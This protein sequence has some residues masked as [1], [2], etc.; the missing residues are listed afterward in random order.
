MTNDVSRVQ[1]QA[2]RDCINF[3]NVRQVSTKDIIRK[4][5]IRGP[6]HYK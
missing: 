6:K 5:I 3:F 1:K 4:Y 2:E